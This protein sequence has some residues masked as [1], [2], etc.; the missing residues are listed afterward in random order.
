MLDLV[1]LIYN[2]VASRQI[3]EEELT[4]LLEKS[5]SKLLRRLRQP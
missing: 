2:S 1:H 3:S 5:R 4:D